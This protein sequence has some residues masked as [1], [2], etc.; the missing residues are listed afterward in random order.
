MLLI[1]FYQI[2]RCQTLTVYGDFC[3]I[4]IIH[5]TQFNTTKLF[6]GGL[7][8]DIKRVLTGITR[9]FN[10]P[11]RRQRAVAKSEKSIW[12]AGTK[13]FTGFRTHTTLWPVEQSSTVCQV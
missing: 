9:R 6:L 3:Y 8:I 12:R 2:S 11:V 10:Q 4:L 7:A 13:A 5:C 1:S